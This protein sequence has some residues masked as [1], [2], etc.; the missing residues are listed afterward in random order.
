MDF[1]LCCGQPIHT[2]SPIRGI[3]LALAP[4]PLYHVHSHAW[5]CAPPH[6]TLCT[7]QR[8][9]AGPNFAF[10][11]SIRSS[12]LTSIRPSNAHNANPP[13]TKNFAAVATCHHHSS[14]HGHEHHHHPPHFASSVIN[15]DSRRRSPPS[16]YLLVAKASE[17]SSQFLVLLWLILLFRNGLCEK[18]HNVCVHL[19]VEGVSN[20]WIRQ[21][22]NSVIVG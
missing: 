12:S 16:L 9:N 2:L 19:W 17:T 15:H 10:F 11:A 20:V 6:C 8:G 3:M 14:R 1:L 22:C 4:P 13:P 7:K 21:H 18:R 5:A